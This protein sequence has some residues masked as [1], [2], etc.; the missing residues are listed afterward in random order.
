MNVKKYI[1]P[2]N[3]YKKPPDYK[4][5]AVL[6]PEFREIAIM[7]IAGKVRIDFQ[8]RKSLRV[9]TETLLKHD[10]DL[11]VSIPPDNLNPAITLRMNYILWIE[12]LMKHSK[13]EMNKITGV[14]IG[15]GA[16]CIY[17]LLLAKIYG[18]HVIGTEVDK[19]SV[20]YAEKCIARNNLQN[21]IKVVTVNSDGI[22]KDAIKDD[23][24]Y[25]FS[26]CNPPFFESDGDDERIAK[27][28]PPR[29]APS[30]NDSELKTTGGEVAFVTRMIEESVNL[31]N[32]IKIYTTMI[33]RK[34]DLF[35]LKKL[36]RSKDIENITWTEF[37]QGHTTRWG[38][39]WSFLP[40]NVLD[41]NSAPVI[42]KS[43]KSIIQPLKKDF[44]T[45]IIFPKNDKFSCMEDLLS[46]L[47]TMAEELNIK[48][49]DLSIPEDSS[50]NWLGRITAKEKSWEHARRK[51]RLAQRQIALKRT[52]DKGEEHN[53]ANVKTGEYSDSIIKESNDIKQDFKNSSDKISTIR[54]E[55]EES[56][57]KKCVPLL[58]C[59]LLI[60]IESSEHESAVV[61][62]VFR[63]WMIFENGSGGLDAL[64]SLR[65]YLI[66]KLDI[67]EIL[68]NQSKSVK[69]RKEKRRK[70]SDE[71][72][73]IPL[74]Q[75]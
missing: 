30:G 16:I 71:G 72:V 10:F 1:H 68:I 58:T 17:A 48:L 40:K 55:K 33:G 24:I 14:D 18:C 53:E 9:L 62:D 11:H 21:L 13:L 63:I 69:K 60:E 19:K 6:Y 65:Q 27:V 50:D 61:Q 36:I 8:N 52:K 31:G 66:N 57:D 15:T 47:R 4:Q 39:A 59:K 56:S 22:F 26:M 42:R 49:Q 29:N 43:G 35:D 2:R 44:K 20:E 25:D 7:D 37:C 23:K 32:R 12:D 73:A 38:L 28:L 5:L 70:S 75:L 54:A 64:Q 34:A 74:E 41:L 67:R 3:K 45:S 46:F 51:R